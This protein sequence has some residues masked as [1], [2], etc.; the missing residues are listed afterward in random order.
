MT[1]MAVTG[2]QVR[3]GINA[4]KDKEVHREEVG[5]SATGGAST[6]MYEQLDQTKNCSTARFAINIAAFS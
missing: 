2:N 4:P 6:R 3:L 5:E 1:V